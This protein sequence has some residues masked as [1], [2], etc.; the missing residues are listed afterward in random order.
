MHSDT[1]DSDNSI[2]NWICCAIFLSST[3]VNAY[4]VL[5]RFH[6]FFREL[7]KF[8]KTL[9]DLLTSDKKYLHID[10]VYRCNRDRQ[11]PRQS[12]SRVRQVPFYRRGRSQSSATLV[13]Y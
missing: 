8:F 13:N 7:I 10:I 4:Q 6:R 3:Y 12:V 5:H 11:G 1:L 9:V 2:L